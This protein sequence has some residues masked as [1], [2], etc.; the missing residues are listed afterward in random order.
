MVLS[1]LFV[2]GSTL[3]DWVGPLVFMKD[4]WGSNPSI[5]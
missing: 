5:Y 1:S 4:F 2:H 3:V